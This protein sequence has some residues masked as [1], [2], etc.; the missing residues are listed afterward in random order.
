[1]SEERSQHS[2]RIPLTPGEIMDL[3]G[4][5]A[6]FM[7]DKNVTVREGQGAIAVALGVVAA[8]CEL[9]HGTSTIDLALETVQTTYDTIFTILQD[10]NSEAARSIINRFTH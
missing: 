1:M 3:A 6:L 8:Y 7:Q 5:I 10:K 4:E 2:D 9:V